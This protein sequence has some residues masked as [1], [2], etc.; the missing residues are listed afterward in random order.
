MMASGGEIRQTQIMFECP[1]DM[2]LHV[3]KVL[4]GEYAIPVDASR[5]WT[6]LDIGGNCGAFALWAKTVWPQSKV[7]SYEPYKPN[8]Q[9]FRNNL[10]YFQDVN[11]VEAAVGDINRKKLYLG[12]HNCGECSQS[13]NGTEQTDEYVEIDVIEPATLPSYEIVKIDAEGAESYILP[14]LDLNLTEFV[15]LEYHG[16]QNRRA[17]DEVMAREKFALIECH[18]TSRGYGIVKYQRFGKPSKQDWL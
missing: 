2:N 15:M 4:K 17:A 5:A 9:Y 10:K 18:V 1:E 8:A 11:L 6:V 7:T 13:P 12:K 14:R 3:E 16:E